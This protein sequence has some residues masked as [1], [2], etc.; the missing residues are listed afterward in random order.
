VFA[1]GTDNL[2][3]VD[4]GF[5]AAPVIH[6]VLPSIPGFSL[7]GDAAV[8]DEAGMVAVGAEGVAAALLSG[9]VDGNVALRALFRSTSLYKSSLLEELVKVGKSKGFV[10][11]GSTKATV[12]C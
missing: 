12:G 8:A 3:E 9:A 6:V 10:Y 4:A 2:L 5:C 7:S 1:G 11:R